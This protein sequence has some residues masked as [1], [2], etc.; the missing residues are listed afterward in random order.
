M[1]D[2][3]TQGVILASAVLYVLATLAGYL[4]ATHF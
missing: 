2:R 4:I 1:R 3:A